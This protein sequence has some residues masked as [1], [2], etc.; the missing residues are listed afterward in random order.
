MNP[1]A[2]GMEIEGL[3]VVVYPKDL[4]GTMEKT[5]KRAL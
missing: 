1:A 3:F 4:L 5:T 2:K